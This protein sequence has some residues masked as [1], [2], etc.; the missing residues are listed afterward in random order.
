MSLNIELFYDDAMDQVEI[1]RKGLVSLQNDLHNKEIINNIFRAVHSLKGTAGIYN[2]QEI[3]DLVHKTENLLDEIRNDT[4]EM[5]EN[6]RSL[7]FNAK[8]IIETLI[9]L[10]YKNQKV[11][12]FTSLQV[13]NLEHEL[14]HL[15][16]PKTQPTILIVDTDSKIREFAKTIAKEAGYSIETAEN[17][18]IALETLKTNNYDLIFSDFSIIN[19]NKLEM[20]KEIKQDT[21]YKFTPIVVLITQK[22]QQINLHSKS[23]GVT[24]WLKKP[25]NK[26]SFLGAIEKLL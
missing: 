19:P 6:I 13:K 18:T 7:L 11:D 8:D 25:F 26:T 3:V 23:L 20:F 12:Q 22:N 2:L 24:A 15:I 10:T 9:E 21:Q 17:C 1:T 4:L 16:Q 5:S 14:S